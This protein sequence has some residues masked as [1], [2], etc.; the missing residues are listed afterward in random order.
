[1][2]TTRLTAPLAEGLTIPLKLIINWRKYKLIVQARFLATTIRSTTIVAPKNLEISSG[3][4]RCLSAFASDGAR[5][6]AQA[7]IAAT[8]NNH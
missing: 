1:M 8:V 7:N 3:G 5:A 4:G 6:G 2:L